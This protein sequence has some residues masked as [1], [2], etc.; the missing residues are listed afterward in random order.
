MKRIRLFITQEFKLGDLTYRK[1]AVVGV[2]LPVARQWIADGKAT[3]YPDDPALPPLEPAPAASSQGA[4]GP[5]PVSDS[6]P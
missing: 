3:V 5:S 2:T 1:G 4:P 6:A